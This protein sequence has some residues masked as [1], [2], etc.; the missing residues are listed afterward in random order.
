MLGPAME[1][2]HLDRDVDFAP[3]RLI[4]QR[5]PEQVEIASR[6]GEFVAVHRIG[7]EPHDAFD[8]PVTAR[9][10]PADPLQGRRGHFGGEGG[11]EKPVTFRRILGLE[12]GIDRHVH[13]VPG[14]PIGDGGAQR[15]A[16]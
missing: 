13:G 7:G 14:E 12:Q 16:L 1:A 3:Y 10:A 11:D 4:G 6:H 15:G 2:V 8:V 9:D 5:P